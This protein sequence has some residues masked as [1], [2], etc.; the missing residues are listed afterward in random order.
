MQRYS[1][2]IRIKVHRTVTTGGEQQGLA[3]PRDSC[4]T[5]VFPGAEDLV[6]SPVKKLL[7]LRSVPSIR[8][9]GW[10]TSTTSVAPDPALPAIPQASP[11]QGQ[12]GE[13]RISQL[14]FQSKS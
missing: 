6:L 10:A 5:C 2:G 12:P 9:C 1:Y 7:P 4:S 14:P 13:A 8:S 3:L 11:P